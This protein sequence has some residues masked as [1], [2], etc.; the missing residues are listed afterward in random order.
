MTT[1]ARLSAFVLAAGCSLAAA[2]F[3]QD[4]PPRPMQGPRMEMHGPMQAPGPKLT[5]AQEDKL[6]AIM[7]AQEPQRREHERAAQ[8]ARE[9][10]REMSEAGRFDEAKA[11]ALAQAEGKAVAALSLLRARTDAQV[12][13]L[14]TPEQRAQ[15]QQRGPGRFPRP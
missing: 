15:F 1:F 6:F 2:A 7:H 3:E 10:L 13:A 8:K 14:L 4:G 5:E 12:A 9:G 11:A